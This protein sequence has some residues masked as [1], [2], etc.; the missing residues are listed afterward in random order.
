MFTMNSNP[1]YVVRDTYVSYAT[2]DLCCRELGSN[3]EV[4]KVHILCIVACSCRMS[5]IAVYSAS[6]LLQNRG[7]DLSCVRTCTVVGEER[8]RISLLTSFSALF[9]SLRLP[10]HAVSASFG[11]RVNPILCLH[12]PQHP[13]PS[14]VY[15]DQRALRVDRLTVLE[16]GAPNSLCLIESGKILP[17]VKVAIVHPDSKVPCAHTDLGEVQHIYAYNIHVH[18]YLCMGGSTCMWK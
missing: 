11:C 7:I 13:E 1:L 12:G 17:D 15:V 8:P 10:P 3:T 2:I 4:L 9:S 14:T 6:F 18:T 5:V 16:R